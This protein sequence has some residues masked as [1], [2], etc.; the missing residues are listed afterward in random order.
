[1]TIR[2]MGQSRIFAILSTVVVTMALIPLA[3]LLWRTAGAGTGVVDIL[4]D[5]R[6]FRILMNSVL[7][8]AIVTALSAVIAVP[9][10]FFTVRTDLPGKRFWSIAT[11]LPLTVPSY[12][13]SFIIISAIGPRGSIIQNLLMPLGIERLPSIYGLPGA[14]LAMTL[15]TYPY[16]LLTV[17]SSLQNLDPALEEA[18]RNLGY[19]QKETFF[20]VTLPH[21]R[22]SIAAGGL[23]V[24]LYTLSDF[25]TP[26][27]MRFDSFTRAIY[28]QYQS[29]F[30]RTAAAVLALMLVALALTILA[31]EFR[32]MG[33]ASYFGSSAA[34]R[35]PPSVIEL[36]KWRLPALMFTASVVGAALV[37]PMAVIG[38]WLVKAS[39]TDEFIRGLLQ[40]TVN[41]IYVSGLAAAVAV[42]AAL[43]VVIYAVR[44]PGRFSTLLERMTYLGSG[45]PGIVVALSLVF[46][47]AN[48]A[49]SLY[50]TISMLIFAYVVLF[51]PKAVGTIRTSMLQINPRLEEAAR[52]LGSGSLETLQKVTLPLVRP[53]LVNGAALVFLTTIKELPATLILA[54]IGFRTLATRIWSATDD[55]LFA[56]AAA[57]ALLLILASGI[58]MSIILKQE[59][60]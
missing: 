52:S 51:L 18:S 13:G 47:G 5:A 37:F 28:I 59:A 38:Y 35:R 31:L 22:P 54:P 40:L 50:Q 9:L 16:I 17:R 21:L 46:F 57:M 42:L 44:Y 34:T 39:F 7:L 3:Y 58:F 4:L 11:A 20:K 10:A 43:P 27:L 14:V 45:L 25:G 29:S 24:A 60:K 48:F 36:G 26:S 41:S 30:D 49:T 33:K 8:A 6:T 55:A 15:F 1:M 32:A 12:V 2:N 53:G 19:S 23:L 56:E